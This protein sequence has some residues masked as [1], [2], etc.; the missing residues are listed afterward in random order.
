MDLPIGSIIMFDGVTLPVGWY[1]C[2]GTTHNG[3]VTPNLI[4]KFP[5][6]VPSGGTLG[7]TGGGSTHTHTNANTGDA[8]HGHG[9]KNAT[10]SQPSGDI[11]TWA[12]AG[13]N[14]FVSAS[15][16]HTVSIGA[17]ASGNP[18]SHTVPNTDPA[19]SLPPYIRLRYIMRC[20]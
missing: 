5:K 8:S 4:G 19:S 13:Y 15:H 14:E 6:G 3:L 16:T 2:D 18:H 20:E 7:S 12:W 17:V 1:D 11:S 10:T 9:A